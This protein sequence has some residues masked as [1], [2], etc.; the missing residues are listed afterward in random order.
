M[1]QPGEEQRVPDDDVAQMSMA[2]ALNLALFL[3]TLT[4][5]SFIKDPRYSQP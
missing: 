2:E 5:S 3:R 4:D 1:T